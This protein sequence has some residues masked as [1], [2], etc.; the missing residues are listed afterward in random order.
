MQFYLLIFLSKRMDILYDK[1]YNK[2]YGS[3]L[4]MEKQLQYKYPMWTMSVSQ[5]PKKGNIC[6]TT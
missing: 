3:L 1:H 6:S 4:I 5:V 2:Q